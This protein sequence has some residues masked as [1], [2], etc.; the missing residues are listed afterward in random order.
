MPLDPT[1]QNLTENGWGSDCVP[2][3]TDELPAPAFSLEQSMCI[4]ILRADFDI[5]SQGGWRVSQGGWKFSAAKAA[6]SAPLPDTLLASSNCRLLDILEIHFLIC[7]E[8]IMYG[9]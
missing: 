1:L 9:N 6:Y 4:W 5:F 7:L 8:H 3:M 2:E